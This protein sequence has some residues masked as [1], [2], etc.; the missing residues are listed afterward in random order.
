[1]AAAFRDNTLRSHCA[2]LKRRTY[3]ASLV[4]S[5]GSIIEGSSLSGLLTRVE[6]GQIRMRPAGNGRIRSQGSG[7]SLSHRKCYRGRGS[8]RQIQSA[9]ARHNDTR[10][11]FF[12]GWKRLLGTASAPCAPTNYFG[13]VGQ[14]L[15][16]A[17]T[18][19]F[20]KPDLLGPQ[21]L[22]L[23]AVEIILPVRL[24][25]SVTAS[26]AITS[27][28]HRKCHRGRGSLRQ[29]QS[30]SARHNDTRGRFFPGWKRL[31]G[32]ASAPCAP[33]NCGGTGA[34][35]GHFPAFRRHGMRAL[36]LLS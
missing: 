1:V 35:V 34:L 31:L 32:T 21:P 12:P 3:A 8:L 26:S 14:R 33:T 25:K 19:S 24:V 28:R 5:T 7:S 10:G 11:R 4:N 9:S 22:Y 20:R 18:R 30:A 17:S 16:D 13:S 29:I 27:R 2:R 23:K 36:E 15:R 6:I